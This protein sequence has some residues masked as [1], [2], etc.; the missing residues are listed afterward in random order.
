MA[1]VIVPRNSAANAVPYD[2]SIPPNFHPYIKV[3]VVDKSQ[4]G[5]LRHELYQ[6]LLHKNSF[7]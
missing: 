7:F 5:L 3:T 6:K 2:A 1:A 4:N